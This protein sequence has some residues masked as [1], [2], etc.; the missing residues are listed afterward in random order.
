MTDR[1]TTAPGSTNV[2]TSEPNESKERSL[3]VELDRL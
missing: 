2:E 3:T 1:P